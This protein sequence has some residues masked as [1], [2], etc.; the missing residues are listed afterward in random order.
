ML[1]A[2]LALVAGGCLVTGQITIFQKVDEVATTNLLVT[3]ILVDLNEEEDY[4]EHKD[5]IKSVDEISVVAI[6]RNNLAT[7][8]DVE[9]YL[10]D[11][12]GLTLVEIL[13]PERATL[14]FVAP[15]VPGNTGVAG[16]GVL[17]IGWADGFRYV[18]N[19]KAVIEQILGDGKFMLYAVA[20]DE[21]DLRIKA[22]IAVT[23][24]VGG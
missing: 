10:S 21:F 5:D 18:V 12:A 6:I 16:S 14:V 17:K 20:E 13:D 19:K 24:T 1:A 7:P 2:A 15:T 11:E 22:E 9:I 8:A 23:L 3:P 4:V